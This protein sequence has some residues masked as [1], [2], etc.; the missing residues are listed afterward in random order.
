M[1][2]LL[3]FVCLSIFVLVATTS[4]ADEINAK[5]A[6]ASCGDSFVTSYTRYECPSG[7]NLPADECEYFT[8]RFFDAT[9]IQMVADTGTRLL[10]DRS[11]WYYNSGWTVTTTSTGCAPH[12]SDPYRFAWYQ[13]IPER[14][15]GTDSGTGAY[16]YMAV[17]WQTTQSSSWK[18]KWWYLWVP[19]M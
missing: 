9:W 19:V 4:S 2:K 5:Y 8:V 18:S 16:P 17:M 13:S 11:C 6:R 3:Q 12:Y 14:D 15:Y 1:S 7:W 10:Y